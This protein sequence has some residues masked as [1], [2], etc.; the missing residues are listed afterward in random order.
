MMSRLLKRRGF[1]SIAP[2]PF[3]VAAAVVFFPLLGK[4]ESFAANPNDLS[5]SQ[6]KGPCELELPRDHGEHPEYRTEWWYYTGNVEAEKGERFGFQ[7]TFFR[8]ALSP[9]GSEQA[10]PTPS[11]EWRTRQIYLAHAA[12]SDIDGGRFHHVEDVARGALG[13]AGLRQTASATTV[14]LKNWS[15]QL[16][17][18]EHALSAKTEEFSFDLTLKPQ[19]PPVFHGDSGYSRKGDAPESASCYYSFTS[20]DTEGLLTVDGKRFHVKGKSWM[21]HEFSSAPL[22]PGIAGWD[23]FSLQLN[24]GVELMVYLLRQKDGGYN[25]ASSGTFVDAAGKVVHLGVGDIRVDALSQ[26]KSPHSKA[27]YPSRWKL[28]VESLGLEITVVPSLEDQEMKTPG[29]TNITYWEGSVSVTG[30]MKAQPVA[31]WGYAELTGYAGS[32]GDKI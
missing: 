7:L 14:F 25:E 10:W 28:R 8:R 9:P 21:D 26:W 29:S 16:A 23:W 6:I 13:L 2:F 24:N 30:V 31:G 20:L 22:E 19:K 32:L 15:A 17:P 1:V 4:A 18:D 12:V 11:S 27:V 5:Y 3:L